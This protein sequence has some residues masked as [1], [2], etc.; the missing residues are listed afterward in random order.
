[1]SNQKNRPEVVAIYNEVA[2]FISGKEFSFLINFR[3]YI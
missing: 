2:N 1:M 3:Y